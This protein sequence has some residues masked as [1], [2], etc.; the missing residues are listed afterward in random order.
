MIRQVHSLY[1]NDSKRRCYPFMK[2]LVHVKW[3]QVSVNEIKALLPP[4]GRSISEK[5]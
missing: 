1:G 3:I 2:K 4:H 5:N